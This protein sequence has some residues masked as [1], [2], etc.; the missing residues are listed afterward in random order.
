VGCVRGGV[1][2]ADG[3]APCSTLYA[4]GCGGRA[5]FAGDTGGD[6]LYAT[7]YAGGCGRWVVFVEVLEVVEVMRCVLLCI[8]EAV[9]GAVC[10]LDALEVPEVMRLCVTLRAGGTGGDAP[11]ATL[12]AGGCGG[13]ALFARDTG[14]DTLCA[15]LYAGGCGR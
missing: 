10:L 15:A 2:G 7:L 13:R 1:G 14:G 11:C 3:D 5:L 8:L 4:G 6:A 12:Y 9:D